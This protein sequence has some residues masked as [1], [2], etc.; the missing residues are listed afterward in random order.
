M[1]LNSIE[2][3]AEELVDQ[4]KIFLVLFGKSSLLAFAFIF[5]HQD[6]ES[7]G[8][9]SGIVQALDIWFSF[10][11]IC[12]FT[13]LLTINSHVVGENKDSGIEDKQGSNIKK[14]AT[15]YSIYMIMI[16]S[17]IALIAFTLH[18]P[19]P[20]YTSVV[21]G[22]TLSGAGFSYFYWSLFLKKSVKQPPSNHEPLSTNTIDQ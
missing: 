2:R 16:A 5:L 18:T 1:L 3:R 11:T 4:N 10:S 9:T 13:L 12:T 20:T 14:I 6:L 19:T 17:G 22:F 21:C 7:V 15:E 8:I